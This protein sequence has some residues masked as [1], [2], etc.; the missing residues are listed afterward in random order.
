MNIEHDE[1]SL[2]EELDQMLGQ[3]MPDLPEVPQNERKYITVRNDWNIFLYL[4][5]QLLV[6]DNK[7]KMKSKKTREALLESWNYWPN[8]NTI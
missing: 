5:S 1:Q 7:E 4:I 3:S 6:V 8:T 2:I